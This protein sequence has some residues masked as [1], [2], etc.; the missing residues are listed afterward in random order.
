MG[1][2]VRNKD[3]KPKQKVA[4]IVALVKNQLSFMMLM[5]TIILE[6]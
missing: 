1:R 2:N 4:I 3:Q 6:K 5:L